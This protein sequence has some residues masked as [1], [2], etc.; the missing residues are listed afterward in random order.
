[1]TLEGAVE[2]IRGLAATA[3]LKK[4]RCVEEKAQRGEDMYVGQKVGLH[5]ALQVLREEGVIQ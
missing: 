5:L 2:R 3:E 1:M 4:M